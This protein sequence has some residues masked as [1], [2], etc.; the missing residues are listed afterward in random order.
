MDE[1]RQAL[2]PLLQDFYH[3][4][5]KSTPGSNH[6]ALFRLLIDDFTKYGGDFEVSVGC[7]RKPYKDLFKFESIQYKYHSLPMDSI[8]DLKAFHD[9]YTTLGLSNEMHLK[10]IY[11]G[12]FYR[13]GWAKE[14]NDWFMEAIKELKIIPINTAYMKLKPTLVEAEC[15]IVFIEKVLKNLMFRFEFTPEML[16]AIKGQQ[17]LWT[18]LEEAALSQTA[19]DCTN[20]EIYSCAEIL[21]DKPLLRV[22]EQEYKNV[23]SK[24][25]RGDYS[26]LKPLIECYFETV[27]ESWPKAWTSFMREFCSSLLGN[28]KP[29]YYK[30]IK[31]MVMKSPS[32]Y[33]TKYFEDCKSCPDD[34][35]EHALTLLDYECASDQSLYLIAGGNEDLETRFL[36]EAPVSAVRRY[37]RG[38]EG[39]DV[40]RHFENIESNKRVSEI[41]STSDFVNE[42]FFNHEWY[43][44]FH[45]FREYDRCRD[46]IDRLQR[47][48]PSGILSVP[49]AII[50]LV[51]EK[52][53]PEPMKTLLLRRL[54]VKRPS[55]Y[56]KKNGWR[57]KLKLKKNYSSNLAKALKRTSL[58]TVTSN[59]K[60]IETISF[61]L[62]QKIK[63][64]TDTPDDLC[65]Q[66]TLALS[67]LTSNCIR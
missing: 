12:L 35:K 16:D 50:N 32:K 47:L 46:N 25:F 45:G 52:Q 38:F 48:I 5:W 15:Q 55:D 42:T 3:S 65:A 60:L 37:I 18:T 19:P 4:W 64:Q 44:S 8:E 14:N 22:Y 57:A 58:Q 10:C 53:M 51:L 59:R 41:L 54:E 27:E 7:Y 23:M 17:R 43:E 13:P 28:V 30:D 67:L 24:S 21:Q 63:N 66:V 61:Y 6:S 9:L 29:D 39:E 33:F 40:M 20:F 1:S 2:V 36:N 31:N 62:V 26:L 56:A 49:Q 11:E 34:I